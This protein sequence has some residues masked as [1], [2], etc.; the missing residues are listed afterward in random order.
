MFNTCRC[1]GEIVEESKCNQAWI[2]GF[3]ENC[4]AQYGRAYCARPGYGLPDE[5]P[6][7]P[8]AA[9]ETWEEKE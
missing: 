1:G 6:E 7:L 3:C 4:G 5:S 2:R 8:D 9:Y